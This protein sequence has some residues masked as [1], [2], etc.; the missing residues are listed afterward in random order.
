MD[1]P[2]I[3]HLFN[4]FRVGGVERQHMLLVK[5]LQNDFDQTCWAITT[6]RPKTFSTTWACPTT[7]GRSP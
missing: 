6:A 7:A 3:L 2:R 1:K 5:H 4:A